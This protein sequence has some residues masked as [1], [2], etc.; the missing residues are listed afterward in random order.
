MT[1]E[2]IVRE[3]LLAI[4]AILAMQI[5]RDLQEPTAGALAR[6]Q[7]EHDKLKGGA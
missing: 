4:A 7:K 3:T 6:L 2:E 5:P 1:H